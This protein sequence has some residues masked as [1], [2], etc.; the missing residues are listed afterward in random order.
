ME[1]PEGD[2]GAMFVLDRCPK[3]FVGM[4][5]WEVM[6][7]IRLARTQKLWP[8]D[9]GSLDQ[10]PWF[11]EAVDMVESDERHWREY[12]AELERNAGK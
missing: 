7:L 8:V 10:T 3:A 4:E 5:I 2:P 12:Y 1:D 6:R 11:M 9:G